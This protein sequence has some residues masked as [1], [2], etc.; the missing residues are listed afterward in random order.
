MTFLA[1]SSL[2]WRLS[3]L[4][5][6]PEEQSEILGQTV[7]GTCALTERLHRGFWLFSKQDTA[8]R[9]SAWSLTSVD[10]CAWSLLTVHSEFLPAI[11]HKPHPPPG[12]CANPW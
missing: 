12:S 7:L 3:V 6:M 4:G 11:L 5:T 10:Q 9:G 8:S 2:E 1:H